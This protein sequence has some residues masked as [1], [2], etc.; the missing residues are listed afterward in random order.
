M[1]LFKRLITLLILLLS[2]G[3]TA[4]VLAAGEEPVTEEAAE[5]VPTADGGEAEA[6][7]EPKEDDDEEPDCE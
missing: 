1:T 5:A 2:L 4:V 3:F 7:A 6:E